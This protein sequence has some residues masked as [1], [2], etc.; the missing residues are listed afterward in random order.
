MITINMTIALIIITFLI[1]LVTIGIYAYNL[2]DDIVNR[3]SELDNT[4]VMFSDTIPSD[5]TE[6]KIICK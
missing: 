4:D 5:M 2:R 1:S 6:I 3:Q